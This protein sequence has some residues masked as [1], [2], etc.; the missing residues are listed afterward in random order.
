[1]DWIPEHGGD[2]AAAA[3]YF[4]LDDLGWLDLSTGINPQA[5]PFRMPPAAAFS[6]LPTSS[7]ELVAAARAHYLQHRNPAAS[8]LAVI[9]AAGSQA[10]IQILPQCLINQ[11][12][13][14][15]DVG[16]QEYRRQ[17]Q[18][19][20]REVLTYPA[21]DSRAAIVAIDRILASNPDVH[22][23]IINPNNPT[24]LT[25]PSRDI[26]RWSQRLAPGSCLLVDEA[27]ADLEPEQS[28]LN[29][30][31]AD[32]VLVFRSF[33]KFFGLAGLRVGFAFCH[34]HW[35]AQLEQCLGPWSV[36]GPA[37][38]IATQA[39]QDRNWHSHNRESIRRNARVTRQL[40]LPL[41]S[42]AGVR[43]QADCGLFISL[44]LPWSEAH[45][46]FAL[47]AR[48]RVLIR[49]VALTSERVL[50]RF[51]IVDANQTAQTSQLRLAVSRVCLAMGALPPVPAPDVI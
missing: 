3:R 6:R 37:Q 46:V 23:L 1:M 26:H 40:L 30:D 32:N 17:W 41:L 51:G 24:G 20:G 44:S 49:P 22:L 2:V 28:L 12:L 50:L 10:L 47:L 16:Y 31:F 33:G 29:D 25:I 11:P 13:L 9:A 35:Q 45:Q 48:S 34:S 14:V 15:P 38:Q 42:L 8:E 5:Y 21:S 43:E 27:F 7:R 18:L 39:L 36:N 4:G 19:W